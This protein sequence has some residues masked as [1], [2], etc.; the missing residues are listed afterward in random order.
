MREALYDIGS[1]VFGLAAFHM[2]RYLL[3]LAP[4]T[5]VVANAHVVLPPDSK[6]FTAD[7]RHS[8]VILMG[9]YFETKEKSR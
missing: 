7:K 5:V 3:W 4:G 2:C 6:I 9:C 8:R 1:M